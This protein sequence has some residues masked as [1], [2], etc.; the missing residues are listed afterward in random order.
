MRG[1]PAA[2]FGS[3]NVLYHAQSRTVGFLPPHF[4]LSRASPEKAGVGGSTPSLATIFFNQLRRITERPSAQ[5]QPMILLHRGQ[6]T[7]EPLDCRMASSISP[8]A[9]ILSSLT[10]CAYSCSVVFTSECRSKACTVFGSVFER[11]RKEARLCLRLWNPKRTFSPSLSTPALTAAGR[12]WSWTSM[13]AVRG[14]RPFS[15]KE[16]NTQC[17]ASKYGVVFFH[18]C[19][20]SASNR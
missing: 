9:A 17:S 18:S 5:C 12:R 1:L 6:F 4:P 13:L 7:V 8:C 3:D 10:L 15:L 19:M 14:C 16:A 2:P 20:N 11:T